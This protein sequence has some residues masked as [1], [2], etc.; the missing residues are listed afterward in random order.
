MNKKEL[1]KLIENIEDEGSVD[2]VL[3]ESDLQN[4]FYKVV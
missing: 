1:L 4:H 2:E 3:S